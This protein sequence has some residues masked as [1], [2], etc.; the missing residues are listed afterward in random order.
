MGSI[1]K[2][3][4]N[5]RAHRA[6]IHAIANRSPPVR[7]AILSSASPALIEALATAARVLSNQGYTFHPN[8]ARRA[9]RLMHRC[10]SKRNKMILVR[11][12]PGTFS[13]GGDFFKDLTTAI[14]EVAPTLLAA[15]PAV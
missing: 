8:H 5:L 15:A 7:R 2:Q 3:L 6:D 12:K 14:I 1:Q 9:A 10:T 13:R 11:G 4:D